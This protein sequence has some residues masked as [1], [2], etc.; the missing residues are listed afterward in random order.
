MK[1]YV[2]REYRAKYVRLFEKEK[3]V[4]WKKRGYGEIYNLWQKMYLREEKKG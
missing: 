4:R 3:I 1:K 2:F